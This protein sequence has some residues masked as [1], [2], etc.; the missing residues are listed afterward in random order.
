MF[1]GCAKHAFANAV[2]VCLD[3]GLLAH[4]HEDADKALKAVYLEYGAWCKRNSISP[5]TFVSKK[6]LLGR[7]TAT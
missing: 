4:L 7:S 6:S 1:L 5:S 2:M 3:C